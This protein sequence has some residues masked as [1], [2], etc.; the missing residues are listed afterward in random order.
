ME[1]SCFISKPAKYATPL[2]A[3]KGFPGQAGL[4]NV[5]GKARRRRQYACTARSRNAAIGIFSGPRLRPAVS[6]LNCILT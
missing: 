3:S 6:S 5:E 4:K 2:I 1:F